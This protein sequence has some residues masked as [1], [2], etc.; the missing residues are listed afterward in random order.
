MAIHR[1]ISW[2]RQKFRGYVDIGNDADDDDTL[3][4]AKDVL[5]LMAV[6][7]HGRSHVVIFL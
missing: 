6:C 1:H 7:A 5:V 3:L 4:L 2:D